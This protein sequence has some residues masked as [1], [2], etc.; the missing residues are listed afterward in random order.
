MRVIKFRGKNI[1]TGEWVYGSLITPTFSN[2]NDI[3]AH[4]IHETNKINYFSAGESELENFYEMP[5]VGIE[6]STTG[7]YTGMKDKNDKEIYE[8]DIVHCA[9]SNLDRT[10]FTQD[11]MA[12]VEEDICNP[13]FVLKRENGWVEYDFVMCGLMIIEVVGNIYDLKGAMK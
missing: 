8:G 4:Y 7:Q 10:Q 6:R 12:K 5:L 3:F 9:I 13:C 2:S 11:Y 1:E